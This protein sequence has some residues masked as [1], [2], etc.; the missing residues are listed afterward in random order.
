MVDKDSQPFVEKFRP[1]TL[2]EVQG[3]N[4]DISD[5]EDWA[6]SWEK[7]DKPQ[8]LVGEPGVGKTSTAHALS[9]DMGWNILEYNMSDMRRTDELREV[10]EEL[11][12]R[13][14]TGGLQLVFLDEV[15][16]ISGRA[17]M[18]PLTD[19][20]ED[21]PNPVI[22]SANNERDIPNK[23]KKHCETREF[24]LRID[25]RRAKIRQIS[26]DN[27]LGLSAPKIQMLAE[28]KNL[29][30][31]IQDLQ[32]VAETGEFPNSQDRA[33][34]GNI[35]ETLDSILSGEKARSDEQPPQLVAWL[36]Q[37]V[38]ERY[39]GI[40]LAMAYECLSL[41]DINNERAMGADGTYR[42]WR[43]SGHLAQKVADVRLTDPYSGFQKNSSPGWWGRARHN[44]EKD[45]PKARLFRKLTEYDSGRPEMFSSY[46][47]FN[48]LVIPALKNLNDLEKEA[49]AAYY[50]LDDDE[51]E[52]IEGEG[53]D[54]ENQYQEQ[55]DEEE[56][57]EEAET[58][59]EA[60][61]W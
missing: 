53:A 1:E 19:Q 20:L 26:E 33:Y 39:R 32:V 40:E 4:S 18:K 54:P 17:S 15:D 31:A 12:S 24:S 50:G 56:E 55:D 2:S 37:N 11:R 10:A 47:E 52:I 9:N 49:L 57:E 48:Q 42:F 28:E 61:S 44:P 34:E 3:N 38:R 46:R 60:L 45:T 22:L 59:S 8:L 6:K 36:D 7:G 13:P 5:I 23:I 25:S 29:R 14:V 51:M 41:A 30:D 35:F 58:A 21:P 27:D 16:N 43:Y